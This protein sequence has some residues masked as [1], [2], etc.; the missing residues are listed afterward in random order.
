MIDT[1]A[2]PPG[3]VA[4]RMKKFADDLAGV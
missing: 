2:V 3:A 4:V 1:I